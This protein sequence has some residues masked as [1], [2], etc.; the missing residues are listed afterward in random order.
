MLLLL[1]L[2]AVMVMADPL[3]RSRRTVVRRKRPLRHLGK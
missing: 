2:V 1:L 3:A